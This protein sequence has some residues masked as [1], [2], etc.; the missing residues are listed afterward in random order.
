[1]SLWIASGAAFTLFLGAAY[2][3]WLVKRVIY[4]EVGNEHVAKLKDI[5][6]REFL[7]LGVFACRRACHRRLAGAADDL[8][9][10]TVKHV[11]HQ[12]LVVKI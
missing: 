1:M 8:M 12:L 7:V 2:T 11:V 4:G 3:L 5:N 9:H 6:Q 10:A